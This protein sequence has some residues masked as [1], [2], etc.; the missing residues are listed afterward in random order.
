MDVLH[1]TVL[2]PKFIIL[3][4]KMLDRCDSLLDEVTKLE[5]APYLKIVSEVIEKHRPSIMGVKKED[6][7]D[8]QVTVK[9]MTQIG[10][11]D[12]PSVSAVEISQTAGKS[13]GI[14]AI[15]HT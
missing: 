8:N 14:G 10:G 7:A 15:S 5:D 6:V 12:Q 1:Q 4:G 11:G 9:V 3:Q 2:V 13:N